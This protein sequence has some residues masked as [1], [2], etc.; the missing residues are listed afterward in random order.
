M[1]RYAE[2]LL[3]SV[4]CINLLPDHVRP[5]RYGKQYVPISEV[6][7]MFYAPGKTLQLLGF[8]DLKPLQTDQRYLLL[9]DPSVSDAGQGAGWGKGGA[10]FDTLQFHVL[11]ELGSVWRAMGRRFCCV[12]F[13]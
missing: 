6:D 1:L 7:D 13:V 3:A 10:Y 9:G 11:V 12:A 5:C 4:A 2:H 8:V